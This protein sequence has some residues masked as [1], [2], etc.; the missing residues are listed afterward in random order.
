[1]A[2]SAAR[3]SATA[4]PLGDSE[5]LDVRR[6]AGNPRDDA[7]RPG[8][9]RPGPP[10]PK[11]DRDRHRQLA[12]ERRKARLFLDREFGGRAPA[13]QP[14]RKVVA[15]PVGDV[16]P[17]RV[18]LVDGQIRQIGM[19]GPQQIRHQPLIDPDFG[20]R[21]SRV[22]HVQLYR[23]EVSGSHPPDLAILEHDLDPLV[24]SPVDADDGPLVDG[25]QL[26]RRIIGGRAL[27]R[28]LGPEDHAALGPSDIELA[29]EE[30]RPGRRV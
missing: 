16:V 22:G 15:E 10:D 14:R 27:D 17:P 5:W 1:M 9:L 6:R 20:F 28:G 19:L 29:D 13:R 25:E 26:Q 7:P 2:C 18:A 30:I 11:R 8:E 12:G 23:F 24:G 3:K 4:R 21:H